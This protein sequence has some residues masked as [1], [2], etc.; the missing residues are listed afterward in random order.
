[1]MIVAAVLALVCV[2]LGAFI[3]RHGDV[4]DDEVPAAD[5]VVPSAS[6]VGPAAAD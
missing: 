3:P 4:S 5:A 6:G 2:L 1:M